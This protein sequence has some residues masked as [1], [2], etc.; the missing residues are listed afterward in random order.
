MR[1]SD[2]SESAVM[3]DA[4]A[5]ISMLFT[6]ISAFSTG[7]IS[8]EQAENPSARQRTRHKEINLF[9]KV[10]PFVFHG[11]SSFSKRIVTIISQFFEFVYIYFP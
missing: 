2:V 3:Q 1:E 4:N 7:L 11:L 10:S 6:A 8:F 5:F 9:K